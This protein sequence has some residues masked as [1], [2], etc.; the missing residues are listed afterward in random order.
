MKD[1]LIRSERYGDFSGIAELNAAA[2]DYGYGMGETVLVNQLRS[3]RSFDPELSVVAEIDGTIIGHALFTP[4]RIRIRGEMLDAVILAPAAVL[5]AYQKQGAGSRLIAEGLRRAKEKGFRLSVLLGHPEYYARFGYL[6]RMWSDAKVMLS[7]ADI[8]AS[9]ALVAERRVQARDIEPLL[10]M[11]EKWWQESEL[12]LKPGASVTDWLSPGAGIRAASIDIEGRL[13]GYVRYD[14]RSPGKVLALLAED[15]EAF[16]RI[17][18]HLKRQLTELTPGADKLALPLPPESL[19]LKK[20]GLPYRAEVRTGPQNM[21]LALDREHP[22]LA[23]YCDEAAAG[24]R[25]P[26]TI[27]WPVEFDVL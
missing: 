10:A 7:C 11:W 5:P 24:T 27:V 26:G 19:A 12:A 6:P 15:G 3:R 21:L 2:F 22:A 16:V 18:A 8:P 1:F 17:C 13:A 9:T 4:Q 20:T 25:T 23:G 14:S